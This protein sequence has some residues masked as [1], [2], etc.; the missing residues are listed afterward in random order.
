M[1]AIPLLVTAAALAGCTTQPSETTRTAEG[2]AKFV[3]LTAGKVAGTPMSCLPSY[4][5]ND[6]VTIDDST[7]A[8]KQG[9]TVYVNHL[10]GPCN[11]LDSGF[12]TLVTRSHGSGMCRGD[13]SHVS[14]IRTGMMVGSCAIGDF[15]PYK[16]AAR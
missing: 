8:F 12:Y 13:I 6:M 7:V 2:Q 3:K 4:Q 1:R 10:L 15:V 14:D 5:T 11:G 16:T 9:S